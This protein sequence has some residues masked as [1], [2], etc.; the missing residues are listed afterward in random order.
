MNHRVTALTLQKRNRQ[1]VNVYLDGEF[2]FGLARIVAAWLTVGIELSDEKILQLQ[3]EDEREKAFQ[4][5]LN[6]INFR[7]RTTMEV[8]QRLERAAVSQE[9]IEYVLDRLSDSG[10]INDVE[11]AHNWVEN[12]L[13]LHPR[14]R[15]A[16]A[17]ELK[18]RGIAPDIIQQSTDEINEEEL[19]YQAALRQARRL[20]NLDRREFRQKMLRH[21]A[22]R[23]FD[24]ETCSAA[25]NRVWE[26]NFTTEPQLDEEAEP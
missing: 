6:Y 24:Y 4:R 10:L 26:E 23:G 12:R 21:L 20:K 18:Q 1:R 13:D 25:A 14:G 2:A 11:F 5:A 19:A 17:Y 22:Q 3:A 8:R 7:P 9:S 15:R 16:L